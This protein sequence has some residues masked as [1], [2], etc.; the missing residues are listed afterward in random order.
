MADTEKEK[1]RC[2]CEDTI[3]VL[4]YV[5][6]RPRIPYTQSAVHSLMIII[7]TKSPV[8]NLRNTILCTQS[9]LT[10]WSRQQANAYRQSVYCL[11]Y[12]RRKLY[13][14]MLLIRILTDMHLPCR[15]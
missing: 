7:H 14:D 8:H 5:T 6:L 9:L 11:L 12:V 13:E 4:S 2:F 10:Q 1:I 15:S 3:S